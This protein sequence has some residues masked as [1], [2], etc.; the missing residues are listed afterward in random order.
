M[1]RYA[2][3]FVTLTILL[4][5]FNNASLA[6]TCTAESTDH[7]VAVLELYTSEGC[8]SCPPADRW[9]NSL[10][11]HGFD[12]RRVI[13]LA[14]HVDYWDYIGWSDRFA[15][16]V[17]SQ[18][19]RMAAAR[20]NATFVYTP[21]F[22]IDGRDFRSP[23]IA[24]RLSDTLQPINSRSA[25]L[26]MRLQ[27]SNSTDTVRAS[28][29][30]AN[31]AAQSAHAYLVLFEN[32]LHSEI[33]SG[34]NAGKKLYHDYVVRELSDEVLVAPGKTLTRQFVI[35]LPHDSDRRQL[36]LAAIAEDAVSGAT[37]QAMAVALCDG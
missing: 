19:Q 11:D 33:K 32:G 26:K 4:S 15:Q 12:T 30:I 2:I 21:Q 13:P 22:I 6:A 17:F 36:G 1:T 23:W 8:S 16:P 5:A 37:M 7:R 24:G 9:L 27:Q 34:E 14:F 35:D 25:P 29:E 3:T 31:R 18:R 10:R 20:N 28:L